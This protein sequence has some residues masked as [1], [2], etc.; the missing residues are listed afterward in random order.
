MQEGFT[1]DAINGNKIK[2]RL[3]FFLNNSFIFNVF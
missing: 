3:F 2:L 1:C